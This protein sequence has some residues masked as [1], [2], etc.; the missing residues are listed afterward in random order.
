M[1]T[2][3]QPLFLRPLHSPRMEV[4]AMKADISESSESC[5]SYTYLELR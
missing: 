2:A 3:F 4:I 1:Q 5:G